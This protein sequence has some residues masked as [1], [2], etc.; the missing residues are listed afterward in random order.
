MMP[1]RHYTGFIG[2]HSP[3][4]TVCKWAQRGLIKWVC[5]FLLKSRGPFH[6]TPVRKQIKL[7]FHHLEGAVSCPNATLAPPLSTYTH[8]TLHLCL[9]R[10]PPPPKCQRLST[11]QLPRGME[12]FEGRKRERGGWSVV[13]AKGIGSMHG[14]LIPASSLWNILLWRKWGKEWDRK[15]ILLWPKPKPRPICIADNKSFEQGGWLSQQPLNIEGNYN[16]I[17]PVCEVY[18]NTQREDAVSMCQE[19]HRHNFI[20]FSICTSKPIYRHTLKCSHNILSAT[21]M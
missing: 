1:W 21:S 18:T 12:G 14:D 4:S 17:R 19:V 5:G 7:Q 2:A 9:N 10:A 20:S 15:A 3:F 16:N 6:R 13:Q 8:K 11:A